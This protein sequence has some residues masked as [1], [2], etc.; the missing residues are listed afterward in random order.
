MTQWGNSN[1]VED[2]L[3]ALFRAEE[4]DEEPTTGKLAEVIGVTASTVSATLKKLNPEGF[5][6]YRPYGDIELTPAGRDIAI[7]VIRRRRIIETYLS[8][9]LGLGAHELHGE[10]DLLEHAVSPLV[11]EKMFQAVGY[12]TLDPH[13]DPIPTESGEMTIN[14]GLMLLG[15]KAGASATVT[16][17]R[18]GNPSVVRYLTGV[19]ITVGT[20]VTV[21]EALSDIATL[22]LQIGEMFQDIPLA[23]ANAVRV[24]R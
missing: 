1:V 5:V 6:N 23:V 8:E 4:W 15:L 10:A 9:K 19:G 2:Y 3:T 16:R 11:L 13:G 14:D 7:N 24:S 22:R 17:V 18:D 21:V 20:T 12:P